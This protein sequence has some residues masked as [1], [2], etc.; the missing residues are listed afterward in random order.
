M[1]NLLPP[2]VVA[3]TSFQ[4]VHPINLAG[5]VLAFTTLLWYKLSVSKQAAAG[6]TGKAFYLPEKWRA[7]V[8][9][10]L[11]L[12]LLCVTTFALRLFLLGARQTPLEPKENAP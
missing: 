8:G 11:K 10:L 6:A 5:S 3:L 9:R 12:A 2:A 7:L 4:T 1:D